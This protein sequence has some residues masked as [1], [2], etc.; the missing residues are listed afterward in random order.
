MVNSVHRAAEILTMLSLGKNRIT[1]IYNELGLSKSTAHRLLKAL[2]ECGLVFQDPISHKYFLGPLIIKLSSDPLLS[3][4]NLILCAHDEMRTLRDVSGETVALFL[5]VGI[6]RLCLE[7]IDSNQSIKYVV[8]K[9]SVSPI[10]AGSAGRVILSE[11]SKASLTRLLKNITF[12]KLAP[13]TI[14]DPKI[15]LKA[16]DVIRKKGYA[17]SHSET[18]D[19]ALSISAPVRGYH[20][21]VAIGIIGPKYRF[22]HKL[23]S[24]VETIKKCAKQISDKITAAS[25]H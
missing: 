23:D 4:Q 9:G 2:E 15:L 22:H 14:T 13:N 17:V 12:S 19:G 3:H 5:P 21:P 8:E 24:L 1:D 25:Q 16:L 10:Y 11:L 20:Y 18:S 7:E 6:N